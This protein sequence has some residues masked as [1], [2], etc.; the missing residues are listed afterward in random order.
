MKQKD[1]AKEVIFLLIKTKGW[2]DLLGEKDKRLG[3]MYHVVGNYYYEA[4][5]FEKLEEQQRVSVEGKTVKQVRTA[6]SIL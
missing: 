3:R 5:Q 1:S 6:K 2:G 4:G